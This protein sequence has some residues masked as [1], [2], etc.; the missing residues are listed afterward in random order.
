MRSTD[1]YMKLIRKFP[2][3]PIRSVA[4]YAAA[5]KMIDA[6]AVRSEAELDQG[7]QDYLAVLADLVEAYD[8]QHH[9]I[10]A[11]TRHP[12]E[13]VRALVA[14]NGMTQAD[15]AK[16][17][18]VVRSLASLIL[19]GQRKITVAHAKKLGE[20]FRLDVGYFL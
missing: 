16:L 14:E 15:L 17:L 10:P 4:D 7:E 13:K 2:L 12:H 9:V 20:R 5:S 1:S 11:D 18:G 3:R 19:S 8:D 6:L